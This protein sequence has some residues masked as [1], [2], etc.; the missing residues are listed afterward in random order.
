M[1]P[2][3]ARVEGLRLHGL[4]LGNPS[5][6]ASEADI[7]RDNAKEPLRLVVDLIHHVLLHIAHV[8]KLVEAGNIKRMKE[9]DVVVVY[10]ALDLYPSHDSSLHR[11]VAFYSAS[12]T[13]NAIYASTA[14]D[15]TSTGRRAAPPQ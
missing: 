12:I 9:E 1:E 13:K 7:S 11:T 15:M 2:C 8:L 4:V 3:E 6:H 10:L 5:P 14:L